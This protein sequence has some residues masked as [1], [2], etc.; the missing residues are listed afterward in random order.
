MKALQIGNSHCLA[1][2]VVRLVY[3]HTTSCKLH[4]CMH[5]SFNIL[6][7]GVISRIICTTLCAFAITTGNINEFERGCIS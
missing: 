3:T 4:C 1:E 6:V 2:I 5:S 7:Q